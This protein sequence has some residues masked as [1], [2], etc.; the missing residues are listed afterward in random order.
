MRRIVI[1]LGGNALL[2]KGQRGTYEEQL[3]NATRT[4]KFLGDIIQ[5]GYEVIITHGNGPQVGAKMLQYEYAKENVPPFPLDVA[6]AETQAL[7][8]YMIQQSLRNELMRR[9]IEREVATIVTQVVVD[10]NDPAFN[11]PT[12]YIGPYYNEEEAKKLMKEKGWIMKPDPRGGWRRVVPSPDPKDIVEKET[13]LR[14]I[15]QGV[16]VITVGG[17]GIP[18][19][20][21]PEGY[22][23]VEAVI[24]KD[25]AS[26]LVAKIAKADTMII[27]TDV[28]K[29]MLNYGKPNQV[30]IDKMTVSE[31]EK[32]YNEGHFPPGSMGPKILALIRFLRWGGKLGIVAHLEKAMEAL[33]GKSGTFIIPDS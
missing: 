27:L 23:G 30:P 18:V 6:N 14:L 21:T 8:G 1:A 22:K 5:E 11:N 3:R 10:P 29:V 26:A 7:I 2:K 32:Y 12:K 24:D 31:A 13:I 4:A 25:L 20:K 17:G 33:K 16:I 19:I 9:G 15:N 28:E